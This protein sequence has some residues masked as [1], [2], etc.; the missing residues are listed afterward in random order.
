MANY[1]SY[2]S[3]KEDST[4]REIHRIQ[5]EME[6][7]YR[8]SGLSSYWEW[9]QETEEDMHKSLAEAGFEI[10]TRNGRTFLDEIKPPSKKSIGKQKTTQTDK[11]KNSTFTSSPNFKP[12]KHKNYDGYIEDSTMQELH[13]VREERTVLDKMEPPQKKKPVKYKITAK[14]HKKN[15]RQK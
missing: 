3:Y 15:L 4:M 11:E 14:R 7:H 8:K 5:E 1:K 9:L 10:V 6:E 12:T 2:N 13:L